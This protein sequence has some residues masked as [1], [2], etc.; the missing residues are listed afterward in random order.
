M[1]I[2]KIVRLAFL[3]LVFSCSGIPEAPDRIVPEFSVVSSTVFADSVRLRAELKLNHVD[4]FSEQ[5]PQ[6]LRQ[7]TLE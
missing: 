4:S 2:R 7:F 5:I 3:I 1:E 6:N